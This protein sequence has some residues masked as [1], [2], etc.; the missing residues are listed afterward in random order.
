MREMADL[1]SDPENYGR[2]I[3]CI[4]GDDQIARPRPARLKVGTCV[5]QRP[6]PIG[7]ANMLFSLFL[8]IRRKLLI[9]DTSRFR[10]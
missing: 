2:C 8:L 5:K 6:G 9:H 10:Q 3:P 1:A 4:L 7:Q